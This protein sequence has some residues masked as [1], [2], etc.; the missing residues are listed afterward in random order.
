MADDEDKPT[1][2]EALELYFGGSTLPN[3]LGE[4]S[5]GTAINQLFEALK[6]VNGVTDED[7]DTEDMKIHF[8]SSELDDV[9]ESSQGPSIAMATVLYYFMSRSASDE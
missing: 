2:L 4:T 7:L 6:I 8:S 9:I 5:S 1:P 3:F